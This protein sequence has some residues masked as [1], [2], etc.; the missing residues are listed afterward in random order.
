MDGGYG[1][2][3]GQGRCSDPIFG[4]DGLNVANYGVVVS[5][6]NPFKAFFAVLVS[7]VACSLF[8]G[9]GGGDGGGDAGI[10]PQSL[11]GVT[12]NFGGARLTFTASP[13]NASSTGT[14]I[15]GIF[16]ER[17]ND[18]LISF[19]PADATALD[20]TQL[21]WPVD[22]GGATRYEYT[23]IDGSTGRLLVYAENT[24]ANTIF[25][26]AAGGVGFD[27]IVLSFT[28]NGGSIGDIQ[29]VLTASNPRGRYVAQFA[30]SSNIGGLSE[31]PRP[32]PTGW[33]GINKGP[34]FITISSFNNK[35]LTL[36]Q[37]GVDAQ[38]HD[39]EIQFGPFIATGGVSNQSKT[40]TER[41]VVAVTVTKNLNLPGQEIVETYQAGYTQI[42]PYGTETVELQI[43]YQSGT[44]VPLP[45]DETFTLNFTGGGII[46]TGTVTEEIRTGA[47]VRQ[48]GTSGLFILDVNKTR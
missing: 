29:A 14:E 45:T 11:N 17:L 34:G 4:V 38:G 15:G 41:G 1:V 20:G 39:V 28:A 6:R 10:R 25:N 44:V 46:T 22:L 47:Y 7:A 23:P 19:T 48:D 27:T 33:D 13:P 43:A 9:C 30:P 24:E 8:S 21:R 36:N 12:L 16:Y 26:S 31:N 2:E 40:S 18:S 37:A 5:V 35:V 3:P 32:V 42:Q